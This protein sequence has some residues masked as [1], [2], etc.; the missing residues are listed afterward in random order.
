VRRRNEQATVIQ[1]AWRCFTARRQRELLRI[2]RCEREAG[3]NITMGKEDLLLILKKLNAAAR[4]IQGLHVIATA[5]KE[6]D[7]RRRLRERHDSLV[8]TFGDRRMELQQAHVFT[9]WRRLVVHA[10]RERQVA[11]GTIQRQ[12]R[13]FLARR[14]YKRLLDRKH[15]QDQL[16]LSFLDTKHESLRRKLL[17]AWREFTKEMLVNREQAAIAIQRRYRVRLARK[18]FLVDLRRHRISLG[19]MRDMVFS[20]EQ[21]RLQKSWKAIAI[22]AFHRRLEKRASAI[23]IQ[24]RARGMLARAHARKL[25]TRR[26]KIERAVK[27]MRARSRAQTLRLIMDA[28]QQNVEMNWQERQHYAADIQRVF[29]GYRARK[30]VRLLRECKQLL[31]LAKST[32]DGLSLKIRSPQ[33]VLRLCFLV[34][35]KLP[36]DNENECLHGRL[37]LQR[38]WRARI[39]RQKFQE[40]LRKRIGRRKLL[41][42]YKLNAQSAAALFFRELRALVDAKRLK[43]H[44]AARRIQRA[45]HRWLA[46]RRYERV[47]ERHAT[48][49]SRAEQYATARCQRRM[50]A[51]MEQWKTLVLEHREER[52][53]AVRSI[54]RAFRARRAKRIAGKVVA[55]KAAQARMLAE[56]AHQTPLER[57][58]RKWEAAVLEKAVLT[59]RSTTSKRTTPCNSPL[60]K[61]L[62]LDESNQR[63]IGWVQGKASQGKPGSRAGGSSHGSNN[64]KS[65]D[66]DKRT[67]EQVRLVIDGG[68]LDE[69]AQLGGG[70][71]ADV[72]HAD[73]PSSEQRKCPTCSSTRCSTACGRLASSN[74]R[75]AAA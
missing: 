62:V 60:N 52:D 55:K 18:K 68:E 3:E 45:I 36:R 73:A 59:I 16:V 57:C 72:S 54:Q 46:V 58:F 23:C 6:R 15:R 42:R 56:A 41:L 34:L 47:I 4:K 8:V 71:N 13:A 28:L 19:I 67:L 35:A 24:S 65:D 5:K 38:W 43:R 29:R 50:R 1:C 22:H 17:V 14:M 26:L 70:T 25:R 63:P 27:A 21:R 32:G 7:M 11:A 2:E 31:A 64:N 10:R 9:N 69:A 48:S 74:S 61:V 33:F 66:W 75:S 39:Q 51:I 49:R 12:V 30:R 40:S 44:Y 20:R 53:K 37:R